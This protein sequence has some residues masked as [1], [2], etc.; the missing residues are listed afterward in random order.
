MRYTVPIRDVKKE[1]RARRAALWAAATWATVDA[2]KKMGTG[3][4]IFGVVAVVML[5]MMVYAI[6]VKLWW[7]I[8]LGLIAYLLYRYLRWKKER[9]EWHDEIP[10]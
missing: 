4:L 5:S 3:W 10:F 1:G 2:L 6:V 9:Q 7:A 8:I